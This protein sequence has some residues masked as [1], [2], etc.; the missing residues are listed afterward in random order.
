MTL[1]NVQS[2]NYNYKSRDTCNFN[3]YRRVLDSSF[4]FRIYLL[5]FLPKNNKECGTRDFFGLGLIKILSYKD[6]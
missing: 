6:L 4:V 5:F 2:N 1:N 3:L